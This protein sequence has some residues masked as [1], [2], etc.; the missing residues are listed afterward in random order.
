MPSAT[1]LVNGKLNRLGRAGQKSCLT[2]KITK[3]TKVS[4]INRPN[5]VIFVSFVVKVALSY[6]IVNRPRY[7]R[8]FGLGKL[9]R[10]W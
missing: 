9:F 5:F 4:E 8:F 10:L 6:V 7:P 3:D 2:T 1:M